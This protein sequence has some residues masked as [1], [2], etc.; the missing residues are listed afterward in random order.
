M[1]KVLGALLKEEVLT[2]STKM[3]TNC[4]GDEDVNNGDTKTEDDKKRSFSW[5]LLRKLQFERG[6]IKLEC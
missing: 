6:K 1:F 3:T 5:I 4:V 2:A